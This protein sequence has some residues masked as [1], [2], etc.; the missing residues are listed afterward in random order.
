MGL[1][2]S[3]EGLHIA[4]K[5]RIHKDWQRQDPRLLL[6]AT[7]GLETLKRFW[8]GKTPIKED[9]FKEICKALEVDWK[10]IV[11]WGKSRKNRVEENRKIYLQEDCD[12]RPDVQFF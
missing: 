4:D 1:I 12:E 5:A 6:E 9:N 8:R 10:Q 2:A 11:D 7:V 3:Q